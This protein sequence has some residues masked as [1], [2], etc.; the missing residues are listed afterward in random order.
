MFR[1]IV[2]EGDTI[3]FVGKGMADF[4]NN[5]NL[6]FYSFLPRGP[7]SIP[8]LQD[9]IGAATKGWV[10]INVTGKLS[11]PQTKI[12]T[13]SPLDDA[14]KNLLGI[15]PQVFPIGQGMMPKGVSR[16]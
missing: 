5:V 12:N 1:S 10:R 13:A 3:S 11:D 7:L 14:L 4:D 15:A 6:D 16:Q 2:L 9:V 8:I